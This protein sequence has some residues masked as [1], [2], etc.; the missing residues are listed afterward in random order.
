[1]IEVML[2]IDSNMKMRLVFDKEIKENIIEIINKVI[3]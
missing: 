3:E 1:M 2:I